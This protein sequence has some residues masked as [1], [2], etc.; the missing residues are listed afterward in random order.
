MSVAII[1]PIA[2]TVKALRAQHQKAV[3]RLATRHKIPAGDAHTIEGEAREVLVRACE[4][5]RADLAVIGAVSR[6]ALQ[7]LALGST[8]ERVLDFVPCDLLIVKP[9][10]ARS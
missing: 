7:R 2:E 6:G 1:E 9:D 5:Y 8:A 3:T 4:E 10:R